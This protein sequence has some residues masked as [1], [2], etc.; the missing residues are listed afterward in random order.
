LTYGIKVLE[1]EL[2][3]PLFQR[4]PRIVLTDLG[5]QVLPHMKR[6]EKAAI[7][8]TLI[9][10]ASGPFVRARTRARIT[11]KNDGSMRQLNLSN[12]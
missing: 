10:G 11:K 12:Q 3:G 2:G 5:K 4:Y 9:A 7:A 6:M 1:E 8:A